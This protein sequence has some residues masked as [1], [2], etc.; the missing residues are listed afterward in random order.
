SRLGTGV[1]TGVMVHVQQV[2]DESEAYQRGGEPVSQISQFYGTHHPFAVCKLAMLKH[3]CLPLPRVHRQ[4][5]VARQMAKHRFPSPKHHR[6]SLSYCLS[7][8]S[9]NKPLS[10]EVVDG[11]AFSI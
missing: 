5:Y 1:F 10:K 11:I 9:G 7:P 8:F 4:E 3:A 6:C 2:R